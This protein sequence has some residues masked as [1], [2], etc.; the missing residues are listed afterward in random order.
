MIEEG[1]VPLRCGTKCF[2]IEIEVNGEKHIK[3]VL[4]RTPAEARKTIRIDYGAE[5][6]IL[7]FQEEKKKK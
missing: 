2:L 6:N 3:S 4:A 5:A 1:G 7:S